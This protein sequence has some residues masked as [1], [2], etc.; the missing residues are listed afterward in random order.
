MKTYTYYKHSLF[1]CKDKELLKIS[2]K[3]LHS[4]ILYVICV[5]TRCVVDSKGVNNIINTVLFGKYQ[6]LSVLGS[7]SFSTVY[8]SRHLIL[9]CNRAVKLIPKTTG[10]ADTLLSEAQLLKS[11]HHPGIPNV[12][13]VEEDTDYY[14]LIEEFAEGESLEDFLSHHSNISQENF[15]HICLQL[16]DIFLYL[17]TFAPFPILYLDLKPEHIIVCGTQIKLIDFNVATFL[18]SSGNIFNLFGNKDYSA[19]ELFAGAK[20]NP[21]CDIYSIGKIMQFLSGYVDTPL[22]PGIHHIMQKAAHA[23]S[24]CRFETVDTLLSAIK[25]QQKIFQQPHLCK[26]IAIIGSHSGCGV[27]HIAISIVSALNHMGYSAI[28]YEKNSTN[29]LRN[30]T[31]LYPHMSESN[32][33]IRY[34]FFKGYPHYGPGIC[35]PRHSDTISVYDYGVFEPTAPI[36]ADIILFV[37]S[38]SIWHWHHA[39]EKGESLF[40]TYG[41]LTIICNMGQRNTMHTLAEHFRT[42]VNSYPYYADPFSVDKSMIYFVSQL[43]HLPERRNHLFFHLK[44]VFSRKK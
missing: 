13:D 8:L 42:P 3:C 28:Y 9:E 40:T 16:C 34:R 39:F 24:A 10:L 27:T 17:H 44:D 5:N 18:S 25:Y 21:S 31:D 37:C 41:N 7:G 38:N 19:P 43:L 4:I 32:G 30:M 2:K 26:N 36:E 11:L 6:I 23:D 22:S 1:L 14:Y 29:T 35:M 15:F 33:L 12:Y 20:P